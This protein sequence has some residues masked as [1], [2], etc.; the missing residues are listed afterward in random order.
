MR[1]ICVCGSEGIANSSRDRT[2]RFWSL[3]SSNKRKYVSSKILLW[4]SSFTGPLSWILPDEEFSEGE[5]VSGGMDTMV[6][7]WDLRTREKVQ[8]LKG[9]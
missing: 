2:I 8:L 6:L 5:I 9:H 3:D 7:V 1:G 4:H